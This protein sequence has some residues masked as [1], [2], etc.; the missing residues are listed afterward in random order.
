MPYKIKSYG[1]GKAKVCKTDSSK[2]FSKKPLP[3]ARAKAQMQALHTNVEE[4]LNEC[5][6]YKGI[7]VTDDKSEAS[8]SFTI[9]KIPGAE[10]IL[11]FD[12]APD[13]DYSFGVIRNS[14]GSMEQFE[15][16]LAAKKV[17][18]QYGLTPDDVESMG[19]ESY[20]AI[21][22]HM[23]RAQQDDGVREESMDFEA[24]FETII[25]S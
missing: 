12:L 15:D 9:D 23:E 1:Q 7:V 5:Y 10:V 2:C 3:V 4:S 22:D 17:L 25:R 19:Q 13:A 6:E 11:A 18:K 14:D 16:P 24:L 8:V 20:E 21:E